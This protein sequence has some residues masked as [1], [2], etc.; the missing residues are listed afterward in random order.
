MAVIIKTFPFP[1]P[2][3]LLCQGKEKESNRALSIVIFLARKVSQER[4]I[5]NRSPIGVCD[6]DNETRDSLRS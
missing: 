4:T 6:R 2:G 5:D 3:S 1:F